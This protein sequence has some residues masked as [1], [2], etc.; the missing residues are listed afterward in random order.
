MAEFLAPLVGAYIGVFG[1]LKG[2]A[3]VRSLI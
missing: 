1:L 3:F 2:W